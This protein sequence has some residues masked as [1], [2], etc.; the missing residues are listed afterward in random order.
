MH[1]QHNLLTSG[2]PDPPGPEYLLM[3][4]VCHPLWREECSE[5]EE[6]GAAVGG[7]G[8]TDGK[9]RGGGRRVTSRHVNPLQIRAKAE[10]L[11]RCCLRTCP[12][13]RQ[14]TGSCPP[15]SC[16]LK[17]HWYRP[18]HSDFIKTACKF[19][20]KFYETLEIHIV[21][22]IKKDDVC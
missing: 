2:K 8:G 20:F 13:T 19:E 15:N 14:E 17:F 18:G 21:S 12:A 4:S 7:G 22:P 11:Q 9:S 6:R 3:T 5:S 16:C 10:N 1:R